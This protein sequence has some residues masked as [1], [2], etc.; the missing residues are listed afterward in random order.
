MFVSSV[1]KSVVVLRLTQ[2]RWPSDCHHPKDY[3]MALGIVLLDGATRKQFL[4]SEVPLY[5]SN[6]YSEIQPNDRRVNDRMKVLGTCPCASLPG[7]L[8]HNVPSLSEFTEK[9]RRRAQSSLSNF[10][11]ARTLNKPVVLESPS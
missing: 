8:V 3:R 2:V 7:Y 11:K 5:T 4:M 9:R 1:C 6:M 10:E